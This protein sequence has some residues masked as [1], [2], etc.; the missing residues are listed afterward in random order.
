MPCPIYVSPKITTAYGF[1]WVCI[2]ATMDFMVYACFV[3]IGGFQGKAHYLSFEFCLAAG[4]IPVTGAVLINFL[5]WV[6]LKFFTPQPAI[7]YL[8][9]AE[10][11]QLAMLSSWMV[12][13][14]TGVFYFIYLETG[15]QYWIWCQWGWWITAN[16]TCASLTTT[17]TRPVEFFS[18]LE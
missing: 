2:V 14:L 6:R 4:A 10:K 17:N 15:L 8:E 18:T 12:M 16:G 7:D 5:S 1:L 13:A 3:A 11:L 9:A